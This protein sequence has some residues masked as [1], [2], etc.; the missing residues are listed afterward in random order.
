MTAVFTILSI[1]ALLGAFDNLWHHELAAQLPRR[2][3]ARRE[4]A[5][6]ALREAIYGVVF[7]GLAWLRWQGWC[8]LVLAA[9]LLLELAITLADFLEEDRTRRLPPF[10]RA[11]HTVLAVGYGMF[12][13]AMAPVLWTWAQLPAGLVVAGHGWVS[14]LFTAFA[15]AVLAWSARNFHA[16]ARMRAQPATHRPA[17]ATGPAVLVTGGTG[18]IGSALVRELLRDGRRVIVYSRD[19]VQARAA[20]GRGVWVVDRLDDVPCETTIAAVVN[21]AGAPILGAPWTQRRRLLLIHSRA[22]VTADIV[23]L[24][25]RLERRPRVLVSAS[26][27]GYYGVPAGTGRI[28]EQAPAEPGRFQSDLCA[29]IE[30]EARRAEALGVR[31]VRL[32]FGIVLGADGGAYPPLALAARCGLAAVLGDGRQPVPWIHRDDAIGLVRW[33]MDREALSGAVNAVAPHLCTQAEFAAAIAASLGRR[34][35]LR[36]PSW[37]LRG[38]LGEM[39]ELLLQGQWAVPRAAL[40]AGYGYRHP[41]LKEAAAALGAERRAAPSR[42]APPRGAAKSRSD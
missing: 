4:L 5:L 35:R 26:A 17:R 41:T 23:A 6:H 20:F 34:V 40:A 24:L 16:V 39:S 22:Q 29:A 21:L 14:G 2:A 33:A 37:V 18:F 27:V 12:L 8:A 30:H 7:L 25:R 31:V 28:D 42:R 36:T 32:R 9:L 15:L 10:E 1:Q 11:L 3:S 13:A 38:G 19:P